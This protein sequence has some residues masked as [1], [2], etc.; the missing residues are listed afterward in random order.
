MLYKNQERKIEDKKEKI[1]VKNRIMRLRS[2]QEHSDYLHS[3]VLMSMSERWNLHRKRVEFGRQKLELWMFVP[4]KL[5]DGVWIVFEMPKDIVDSD[6]YVLDEIEFKEYK[7]A[8]DRVL[9]DG[10]K[11]FY[12][13]SGTMYLQFK[14][15][16]LVGTN[17]HGIFKIAKEYFIVEDIIIKDIELTPT[18]QKQIGL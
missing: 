6:G 5:I 16:H 13:I 9:F 1:I 12:F 14:D 4:C 11:P 8:K 7:E 15:G 2:I 10:F 3:Q 18:A 17:Q